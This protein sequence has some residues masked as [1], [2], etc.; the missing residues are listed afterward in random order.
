[1]EK[2]T[3]TIAG[4]QPSGSGIASGD[5]M[6]RGCSNSKLDAV[7]GKKGVV[8]F[9][10]GRG[11]AADEYAKLYPTR[12]YLPDDF[13]IIFLQTPRSDGW[14]DLYEKDGLNHHWVN[15]QVEDNMEFLSQVL[16]QVAELYG[17]HD[18]VWIAG[19]SQGA[20]MTATMALRGTSKLLAGAFVVAGYPPRPLY[21]DEDGSKGAPSSWSSSDVE[22]K[23]STKMYFYT[24]DR[25]TVLPIDKSFCRFNSVV[26]RWGL[27]P[28][29]YRF[30]S[31]T[32]Y[33]HG[34]ISPHGNEFHALW[35]VVQGEVDQVAGVVEVEPDS[36]CKP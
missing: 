3:F 1:M 19:K 31:K 12:V 18:R 32:G 13:N 9:L 14:M 22:N 23:K 6:V 2:V 27:N 17:G 30:W 15:S 24:G 8:V 36:D 33:T 29:N 10:H 16:D 26:K 4:F 21:T 20:V 7:E 5:L 35:H 34:Q 25:D 28:A 11:G